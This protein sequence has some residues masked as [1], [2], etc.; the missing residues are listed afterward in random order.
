MHVLCVDPDV[1]SLEDTR[2]ELS[3]RLPGATLYTAPDGERALETLATEPIT[4][5]VSD[6]DLPDGS[7]IDLLERVREGHVTLPFV[8]FTGAGSEAVAAEAIAAGVTGYVVDDGT[9]G[10]YAKLADR[11]A[12]ATGG[13]VADATPAV[14]DER[15]AVSG[16]DAADAVCP[17]RLTALHEA[18]TGL[19]AADTEAAVA[20]V[21]VEAASEIHGLAASTVYLYDADANAIEPVAST[22]AAENLSGGPPTHGPGDSIVWRVFERGEPEAIGNVPDDPNVFDPETPIRSQLTVPLAG[23]GALVVGSHEP[24]TFDDEDVAFGRILADSAVAALDQV[25]SREDLTRQNER[26]DRFVGVV[27]HDVRNPLAVAKGRLDL[28]RAELDRE[29]IEVDHLGDVDYALDRIETLVDDLL[30]L[31]RD[32]AAPTDPEAVSLAALVDHCRAAVDT[33]GATLV[34]ATDRSIRADTG[35][36]RQAFE[37]AV[38]NAIEHADGDVVVTV[39]ELADG[40][41]FYLEDDGPGIPADDRDRVFDAGYSTKRNGSGFGLRI[42]EQVVEAH[43][44]AVRVEESTAGGARFEVSGVE[45]VD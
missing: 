20:N 36:V 41:G 4:C 37:N 44:W 9:E 26:L 13:T 33:D 16:A 3:R 5:V 40:T 29:G 23:H 6:Y 27:S 24:G 28:A 7:G 32:G 22:T 31:A 30:R 14:G 45:L 39:G 8:L 15:R 38:R 17:R 43:G 18:T 12:E 10:R 19:I 25:S 21:A 35:R 11:I 42:V 2:V 1:G 34:A